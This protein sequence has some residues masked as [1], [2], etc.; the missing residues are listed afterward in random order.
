MDDPYAGVAVDWV[1]DVG[2]SLPAMTMETYAG[3]YGLRS[4]TGVD[5][6][7]MGMG[8]VA[9]LSSSGW[10]P[11]MHQQDGGDGRSYGHSHPAYVYDGAGSVRV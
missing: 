10:G 2:S 4:G 11:G 5:P 3:S 7:R 9:G 1:T 6:T 8:A